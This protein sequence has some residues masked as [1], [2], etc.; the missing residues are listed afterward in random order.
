MHRAVEK[1]MANILNDQLC[2]E[3]AFSNCLVHL[4]HFQ[5]SNVVFKNDNKHLEKVSNLHILFP[6]GLF[7]VCQLLFPI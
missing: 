1:T 7:C 3:Y 5:L 2:T 4:S 6:E